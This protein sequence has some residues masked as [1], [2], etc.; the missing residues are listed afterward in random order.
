MRHRHRMGIFGH[1]AGAVALAT[2]SLAA[3]S[4]GIDALSSPASA[5]SG[6]PWPVYHG[7]LLGS[8][9]ASGPA[10]FHGATAAWTSRPVHGEIYGEP[11]VV[12]NEVIVATENDDVYALNA[13]TG[14][15]LWARKVGTPVLSSKLP[16]GDISPDVGITS[17]PVVDTARSEVFVVADE[18]SRAHRSIS[19][20]LVGLRLTTGAVLLDQVVDPAGTTPAAQ[21][22][23]DALTLD[24]GR[25]IIGSGGNA[26]DCS[27]YHGW[28]VAV[29]ETGG[30]LRTFEADPAAGDHEGA[31]WMGGAAP[32][33]DGA[34]HIWFATGNGAVDAGPTPDY[35]DSVIEL[36]SSLVPLQTFTPSTWATDNDHDRDLGS[37]DPALLSDG[38]VLQVGKSQTAYLLNG[39]DLG[40][41]GGQ[42]FELDS[43]CGK[44]VDGGNAVDGTVVYMPCQNGV[45]AVRV[46]ASPPSLAVLWQTSTGSPG[47][48]I[49]ADGL[50]WTLNQD[51]TL[52]G[53]NPATGNAVVH[54]SIGSVANHFP[55]PS[56]GDG[57]LFVPGATH[58]YAF[59]LASSA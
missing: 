12:G 18:W 53:L 45:T 34:G 8:G 49:V 11:L 5:G 4:A 31:V 40:G 29:P 3:I 9:V 17:T 19:H 47:P 25:V 57:M 42:E 38:L 36:S 41:V 23:R 24:A 54:F 48:A 58:V 33:V 13:T 27:T 20:H 43:F 26:G 37:S 10:T 52:Y 56:V 21:L 59:T 14:R 15:R 50:V 22:Q 16:C 46:T 30:A 1:T 44:N 2:L 32:V 7:N 35:G 6:T 55:T 28:I 51:G 39:S